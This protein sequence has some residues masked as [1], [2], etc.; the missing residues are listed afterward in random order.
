MSFLYRISL[1]LIAGI[2][3]LPCLAEEEG[4]FYHMI[5]DEQIDP[6][7]AGGVALYFDNLC[8]EDPIGTRLDECLDDTILVEVTEKNH[9]CKKKEGEW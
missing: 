9:Y 7:K 6:F 8:T 3:A 2:V 5:C 1:L 4:L